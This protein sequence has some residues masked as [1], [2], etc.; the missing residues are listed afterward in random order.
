MM[1]ELYVVTCSD[2]TVDAIIYEYIEYEG[3]V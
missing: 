1:M 2:P 3:Q